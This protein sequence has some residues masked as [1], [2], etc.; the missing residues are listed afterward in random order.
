MINYQLVQQSLN[1][2]FP[3]TFEVEFM[4]G[5]LSG[6]LCSPK[7]IPP[8]KWL[9]ILLSDEDGNDLEFDSQEDAEIVINQIMMMHNEIEKSFVN[10]SFKPLYTIDESIK[11][12]PETAKKWCQG[13]MGGLDVLGLS[14]LNNKFGGT[15]MLP[16]MTLANQQIGE[17]SDKNNQLPF[18]GELKENYLNMLPN[19]VLSIRIYLR[20]NM[21]SKDKITTPRNGPCTCGSGKKYKQ[22]CGKTKN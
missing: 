3:K 10:M 4:H 7:M 15:V 6:I 22:C 8:S 5:F 16:L 1:K 20:N 2:I 13:F 9:N 12:L 17:V 14:N 11:I 21:K 19:S 18:V